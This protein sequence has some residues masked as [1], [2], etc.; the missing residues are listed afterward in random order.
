[1]GGVVPDLLIFLKDSKS[2]LTL[3]PL[4][5]HRQVSDTVP[6]KAPCGD[7]KLVEDPVSLTKAQAGKKASRL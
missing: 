3:L 7:C 4:R 5:G 2:S 6:I 1:M